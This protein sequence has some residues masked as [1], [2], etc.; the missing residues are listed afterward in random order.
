MTA[1]PP[2]VDLVV[3]PEA[4]TPSSPPQDPCAG[5]PC[6]PA[7]VCSSDRDRFS[8]SCQPGYF[9]NPYEGCRPECTVNSDCPPSRACINNKCV[10]PCP[11]SCGLNADCR[12]LSHQPSCYC[13]PGYTGNPYSRCFIDRRKRPLPTDNTDACRWPFDLPISV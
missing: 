2:A 10:N 12:V 11:G 3:T 1:C 5:S 7:A 6:G 13:P 9:G 8:C 4:E